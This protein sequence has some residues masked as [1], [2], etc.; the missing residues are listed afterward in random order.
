MEHWASEIDSMVSKTYVHPLYPKKGESVSIKIKL[1]KQGVQLSTFLVAMANGENHTILCQNTEGGYA[2][3]EIDMPGQEDLFWYFLLVSPKKAYYY[4]KLGVTGSVPSLSDCFRLIADVQ[5]A[6]W[7][8]SSSCYQIFP[9]RFK[10]G[11]ESCG[12]KNGE[13]SFDGGEVS[14]HSFDE[15]PLDFAH[16][17]CLDFFNGDLKGIEDSIPYFKEIGIDTLYLNPIGVSRTTHRYDCCDF[18]HIDRKLGGDKAFAHLCE[19]L[20]ENGMKIIIDISIN[21]TGIGHPWFKKALADK[22]CPEAAYYY[23]LADGSVAFWQNV[24]TLPQLNYN[25]QEL[26]DLMYRNTDS[27]MRSFLKKPYLQD[28]WRLDVA[29]EVGRRGKD[30]FCQE[31]WREVHIAVKSENPKAYLVGENWSDAS[32]YLQ[33]DQWDATMNYLGCSRPLRSWMGETD[34][35]L[36]SG[37]GHSP[38]PTVPYSG[39]EL[40]QALESQ[41]ASL[42]PQM[43]YQQ[44]NLL[45]SHDT[46]RLHNNK[47]IFDWD[48]YSGCVY[49]MYLLPGMPSV[50]YGDEVGLK[51]PYGSVEDSRFPMQWDRKKWDKR[52][53]TL[54]TELGALRK[55]Y[56]ELVAFGSQ[57]I[58]YADDNTFCFARYDEHQVVLAILNRAEEK[59][60]IEIPNGILCMKHILKGPVAIINGSVCT[61]NLESKQNCIVEASC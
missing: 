42:P 9:D 20:H 16:G 31:I 36:S 33:G 13:Y 30:Q 14:T 34:R 29:N 50:Y 35:F 46:P 61:I 54:Y 41:L 17:R 40:Q 1:P 19:K 21:H 58:V 7:V 47:D 5:P 26:R 22:T 51:G 43:W 18:F 27:A 55:Q 3:S 12:A 25:S 45:D 24:P 6:D 57:K 39:Y 2:S 56:A 8:S 32:P 53:T 15:K 38:A 28:G 60:T 11:D 52:F 4:S 44:M 59:K 37:W 48:V 49:L 10:K 23:M